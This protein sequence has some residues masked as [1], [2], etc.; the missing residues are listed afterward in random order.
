[1]RDAMAVNKLQTLVEDQP[2]KHLLEKIN[3]FP[4]S[5]E[6][7][8]I[9]SSQELHDKNLITGLVGVSQHSEQRNRTQ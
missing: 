7:R 4:Y 6:I 5:I 2:E 9:I 1:M 3:H 8:F